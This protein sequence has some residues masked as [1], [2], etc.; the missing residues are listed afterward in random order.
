[1]AQSKSKYFKALTVSDYGRETRGMSPELR[2]LKLSPKELKALTPDE[3]KSYL[4]AIDLYR[5]RAYLSGEIVARKNVIMTDKSGLSRKVRQYSAQERTLMH[6]LAVEDLSPDEK[7]LAFSALMVS[8]SKM[9]DDAK[10]AGKQYESLRRKDFY[11]AKY[12]MENGGFDIAEVPNTEIE[13]LVIALGNGEIDLANKQYEEEL[14]KKYGELTSRDLD[15]VSSGDLAGEQSKKA[16]MDLAK[17]ILSLNRDL[18]TSSIRSL[19]SKVVS[20]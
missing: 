13:K 16:T 15:K 3:Q 19:K 1:M 12:Y 8:L 17:S 20:L 5:N 18:M 9:I 4:H 2:K 14:M 10:E 11:S 7:A 6:D